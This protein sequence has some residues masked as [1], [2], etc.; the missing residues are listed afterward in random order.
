MTPSDTEWHRLILIDPNWHRLTP[1]DLDWPQSTLIDTDWHRFTPIDLYWLRLTPFNTDWQWLTPIDTYLH[2]LTQIDIDILT[3]IYWHRSG[4]IGLDCSPLISTPIN[5]ELTPNWHR[6]ASI[7]TEWHRLN[8]LTP[9]ELIDTEWH[10]MTP[11][12]VM[13]CLILETIFHALES[14][15][16]W[17]IAL[18]S[19]SALPGHTPTISINTNLFK[20]A[21]FAIMVHLY[22]LPWM[23]I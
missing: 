14:H 16:G 1:I 13:S 11:I 4:S 18:Y 7:D 9:I 21:R 17:W 20:K 19:L 3:S 2:L 10:K 8:R 6:L 12:D 22:F 15:S 23:T 5:T